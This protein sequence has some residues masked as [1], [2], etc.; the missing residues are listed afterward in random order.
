MSRKL[1]TLIE[2]LVVVAV[3]AILAALLLPAL[4]KAKEQAKTAFCANSL[5][6]WAV[7]AESYA[8]DYGDCLPNGSTFGGSG[9]PQGA[10]FSTAWAVALSPYLGNA[11]VA[12]LNIAQPNIEAILGEYPDVFYCPSRARAILAYATT[13]HGSGS[14][15]YPNPWF[16]EIKQY[17]WSV[18]PRSSKAPMPSQ[19]C[20]LGDALSGNSTY[21]SWDA[22]SMWGHMDLTTNNEPSSPHAPH[23][24]GGNELYADSHVA[25]HNQPEFRSGQTNLTILY[26]R[27]WW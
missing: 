5:K 27:V 10:W 6:Q 7:A 17:V 18:M 26:R 12:Q 24:R 21:P 4:N 8:D 25:F 20:L 2:L 23:G 3:I 19:S 15:Y 13:T 9:L 11:K 22:G 16:F 1:F 14:N